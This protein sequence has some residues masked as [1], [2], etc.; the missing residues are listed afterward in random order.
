MT[1]ENMPATNQN[2]EEA[3]LADKIPPT[4]AEGFKKA[5]NASANVTIG[6]VKK[7]AST[8]MNT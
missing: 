7:A 4:M 3:T 6:E 1:T 8:G 2:P 5:A